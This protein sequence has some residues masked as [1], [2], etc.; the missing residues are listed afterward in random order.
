MHTDSHNE[1]KPWGKWAID[2]LVLMD[3]LVLRVKPEPKK[4]RK[5]VIDTADGAEHHHTDISPFTII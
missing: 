2:V 1:T 3:S 4:L 5:P